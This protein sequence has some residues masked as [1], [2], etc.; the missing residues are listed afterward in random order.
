MPQHIHRS[1]IILQLLSSYKCFDHLCYKYS[2]E[3]TSHIKTFTLLIMNR[4]YNATAYR[5][6]ISLQ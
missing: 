4:P 2:Q 1:I 3:Q 6:I 5:S